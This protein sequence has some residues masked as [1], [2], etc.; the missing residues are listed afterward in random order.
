MSQTGV[1]QSEKRRTRIHKNGGKQLG[2][3]SSESR[4]ARRFLR[5][6]QRQEGVGKENLAEDEKCFSKSIK[7]DARSAVSAIAT[8]FSD[9]VTV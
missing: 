8:S 9:Q 2:S 3:S 6:F 5:E 7:C 1:S 4:C